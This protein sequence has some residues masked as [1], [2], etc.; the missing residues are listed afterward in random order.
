MHFL[1][2][3]SKTELF[4]VE[5]MAH[6]IMLTNEVS[7][8]FG[9]YLSPQDSRE[10]I[11]TRNT[12]LKEYGRVEVDIEITRKIIMQF[13]SSPYLQQADYMETIIEIQELFHY[14]KNELD[15]DIGDDELIERL[16]DLYNHKCFGVLDLLKGRETEKIIQQYRFGDE[17]D[18]DPDLE[19]DEDQ[20]ESW[21]DT[22]WDQ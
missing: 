19:V 14:I 22:L 2:I 10:I 3:F 13:C 17:Y 21:E 6:E 20:V 12:I 1:D 5:D 7:E 18:Q 15:D 9:L 16:A 4:F 11:I 8:I